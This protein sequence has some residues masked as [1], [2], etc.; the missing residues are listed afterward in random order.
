[1]AQ[2]FNTNKTVQFAMKTEEAVFVARN[3][4]TPKSNEINVNR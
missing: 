4:K 2:S 1:M 3:R